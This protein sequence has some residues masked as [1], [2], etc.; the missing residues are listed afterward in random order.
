MRESSIPAEGSRVAVVGGGIAGMTAAYLLSRRYDVRLFEA[1]PRLGG[2]T[3]TV[4]VEENGRELQID[5]GFIV[6]NERTYPRFIRLMEEL[7]VA[8]EASTMSFSVRCEKSGLEYNG[9]SLNHLFAQ[10]RNIFR[11]SFYSML[12]GIIRFHRVAPALL[13]DE[14][15]PTLREFLAR[16]RFS[17]PFVDNYLIPM[18]AAI[19]STEPEEMF[20]FPARNLV[21]FLDNHGM[22]QV[23]NRPQWRVITGGSRRYVE[24]MEKFLGDRSRTASPIE[25]VRRQGDRVEVK[26]RGGETES[27]DQVV[28][29]THSDQALRLL[30]DAD[31]TER[32]ILGA[33]PYQDN[34]VVL[35]TDRSLLPRN[36]LVWASWNY[37]LNPPRPN[38]AQMTYYMNMLQNL[39][40][41]QNGPAN[42]HYCVTLN[43]TDE[44]D[45][46]T[47]LHRVTMAHPLYTREGVAGQKRWP[48][49]NG[50]RRTWFCGAWWTWGFHEDGVRSALRV[51]RALGVD[52][53]WA[54]P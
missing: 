31:D 46:S 10:R 6:Y 9:S 1:G 7:K 51:A 45:P 42:R 38:G 11:P 23:R 36:P 2:H 34:D 40:T 5:M 16:E 52:P 44:I 12:N 26:V 22:L 19:W 28:L 43:R 15:E 29:A 41:S 13:E 50:V 54:A 25:W 27:F 49:V 17:G 53:G 20:S 47:V 24:A 21:Q 33:I 30:A 14:S 39:A 35:H 32:E 8:S 37:H 4:P 18:I 3:Y 48:E